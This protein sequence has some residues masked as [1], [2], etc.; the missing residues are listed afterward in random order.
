MN[1]NASTAPL[2]KQPAPKQDRE[3]TPIP[4]E[5]LLFVSANPHGIKLP[6]GMDG[7]NER[8]LPNLIS[9]VQGSV[10][11]EIDW[12]PWL[13]AYRVVKSNRVSRSGT[14]KDAKEIVT[15]ERMGR[16]FVIPESLAVA[17]LADD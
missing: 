3:R 2:P 16:P 6:D 13:R 4:V 14:G 17:I 7:R 5:K 12:R 9:G 10:K 15:W 1:D 11:I 8:I